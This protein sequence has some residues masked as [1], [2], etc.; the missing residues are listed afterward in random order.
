MISREQHIAKAFVSLAD[1][2]AE[3]VDPTVLLDRLAAHCV[4]LTSTDAAGIMMIDA[5][6]S[7]RTMAVSDSRAALLELFQMQSGQGPCIDA[8]HEQH[9]L[10]VPDLATQESRWPDFVPLA[11][12]LG[13]RGAYALPMKVNGQGVGALNLLREDPGTL[14][15]TE[16]ALAQALAD[17][18]CVAVVRWQADPA[19]P[20]D[21]LTQVQ[22]A[23]SVKATIETAKGLLAAAGGI[24]VQEADAALHRYSRLHG[25]SPSDAA[26]QLVRR[27]L[28][29]CEVMAART[30]SP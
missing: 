8:W 1:S 30:A 10:D 13:F 6:G 9:R 12:E 24:G 18:A 20:H 15:D 27:T 7:L 4:A 11:R 21:V 28:D 16:L 5:R 25:M 3:D 22:A 19:R 26:Q 17:V 23:V 2:F 14:T 29:P